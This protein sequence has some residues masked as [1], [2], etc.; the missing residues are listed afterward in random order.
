[1]EGSPAGFFIT[2]KIRISLYS[3]LL[4]V[5]IHVKQNKILK[6][7][8]FGCRQAFLMMVVP[9]SPCI[10]I[11]LHNRRL[12]EI[13]VSTRIDGPDLIPFA[14]GISIRACC[15]AGPVI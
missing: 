15:K 8:Y 13:R 7:V 6:G 4:K 5:S 12:P 10:T 1:M 3:L 9:T 14:W 11:G 2:L